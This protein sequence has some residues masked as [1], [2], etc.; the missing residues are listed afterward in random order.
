MHGN[1]D[2]T[3]DTRKKALFRIMDFNKLNSITIDELEI[4]LFCVALSS[5]CILNR[6]EDIPK[7][8]RIREI[9]DA[10]KKKLGKD[11]NSRVSVDE[12]VSWA[13]EVASDSRASTVYEV[14]RY[15]VPEILTDT[16]GLFRIKDM[17]VT[18]LRSV[19][20]IG[21]QDPFVAMSIGPD[22]STQT[23]VHE[24]AGDRSSWCPD[25]SVPVTSSLV[26][27]SPL[28][29]RVK[30][31][32]TMASNTLIGKVNVD[33]GP[34]LS[35]QDTWVELKGELVDNDD[36]PAGQYIIN[37]MFETRPSEAAG[38]LSVSNDTEKIAGVDDGGGGGALDVNFVA[39]K[40]MRNTGKTDL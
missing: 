40:D 4:L 17:T 33:C 5:S 10:A 32:N 39:F 14:F 21:K 8:K 18:D 35:Q 16:P 37:C 20:M 28:K 19:E 9:A 30:D 6:K 13:E 29:L 12:F 34:L 23:E 3:I 22:W 31:K 1:M 11:E 2:V 15:F 25:V 7:S 38:E 26:A 36:R 27:S 24:G